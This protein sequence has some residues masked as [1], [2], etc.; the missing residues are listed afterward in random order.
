MLRAPHLAQ[1]KPLTKTRHDNDHT[2]RYLQQYRQEGLVFSGI[3]QLTQ[4][5]K[6]DYNSY[7]HVQRT[8]LQ[9]EHTEKIFNERGAVVVKEHLDTKFKVLLSVK[10]TEGED[11]VIKKLESVVQVCGG[12]LA[13]LELLHDLVDINSIFDNLDDLLE[14]LRESARRRK[15]EEDRVFDFLSSCSLFTKASTDDEEL[16]HFLHEVKASPTVFDMLSTYQDRMQ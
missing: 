3:G 15:R 11:E 2:K 9:R 14:E 12:V 4:S 8:L 7:N 5:L 16:F 6:N 13:T 1:P 10:L